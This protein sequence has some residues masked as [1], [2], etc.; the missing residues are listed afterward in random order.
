MTKNK[1]IDAYNLEDAIMTCWQTADD[2][3]TIAEQAK[4][5]P[6]SE[7]LH[8]FVITALEGLAAIHDARSNNL[9]L[10]YETL[11]ENGTLRVGNEPEEKQKCFS[12]FC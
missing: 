11:L 12:E 4:I 9:F 8:E 5:M 1:K 7:E 6:K 2:L 10:H 3:R